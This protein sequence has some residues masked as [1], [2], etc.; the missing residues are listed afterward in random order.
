MKEVKRIV[1]LEADEYRIL[2]R[3]LIHFRNALIAERR[4]TDT[5]DELLKLDKYKSR[6]MWFWQR[7]TSL[8]GKWIHMLTQHTINRT[9][10]PGSP[11]RDYQGTLICGEN[12]KLRNLPYYQ[13]RLQLEEVICMNRAIETD[14]YKWDGSGIAGPLH[15]M[16]L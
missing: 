3:C 10:Y 12:F 14:P 6:R 11:L 5:V 15:S 13:R 1:P 9:S 16:V 4:H 7:N 8:V 2:L